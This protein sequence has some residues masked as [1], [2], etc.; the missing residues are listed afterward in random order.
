LLPPCAP[1][2]SFCSLKHFYHLC[3]TLFAMVQSVGWESQHSYFFCQGTSN[4]WRFCASLC[5][6]SSRCSK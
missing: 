2:A 5:L 4:E 3:L 1:A 6:C